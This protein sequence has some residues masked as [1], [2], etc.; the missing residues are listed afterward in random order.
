VLLLMLLVLVHD[1]MLQV[2]NHSSKQRAA[3]HGTWPSDCWP[4]C[5]MVLN[6]VHTGG[7][8]CSSCC[9]C[10]HDGVAAAALV[11]AGHHW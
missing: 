1:P 11:G 8:S 5:S 3:L 7:S 4:G 10:S 6:E 2:S 9:Y